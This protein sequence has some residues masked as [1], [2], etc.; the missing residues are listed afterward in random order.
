VGEVR[1]KGREGGRERL[2][3]LVVFVDKEGQ[4]ESKPLLEQQKKKKKT[5]RRETGKIE[6]E[7]IERVSTF[8]NPFFMREG[9]GTSQQH[10]GGLHDGLFLKERVRGEEGKKRKKTTKPL[11]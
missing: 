4:P 7:K 3:I 9:K 1:E 8:S 11:S 2:C 5:T 6:R 10:L